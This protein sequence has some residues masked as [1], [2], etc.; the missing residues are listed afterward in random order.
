MRTMWPMRFST[1]AL[2]L[3]L[4]TTTI[5]VA[6]P[7]SGSQASSSPET[8][9]QDFLNYLLAGGGDTDVGAED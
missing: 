4:F 7:K 6:A 3:L 8:S 5:A 9:V 2:V 1:F